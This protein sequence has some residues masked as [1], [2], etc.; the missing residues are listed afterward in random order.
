MCT[1]LPSQDKPSTTHTEEDCTEPNRL[2]EMKREVGF[3]FQISN[4]MG[5]RKKIVKVEEK[6]KELEEERAKTDTAR[7]TVVALEGAVASA[8]KYLESLREEHNRLNAELQSRFSRPVTASLRTRGLQKQ[9][10]KAVSRRSK[11]KCDQGKKKRQKEK[12]R[13]TTPLQVFQAPIVSQRLNKTSVSQNLPQ[14]PKRL[15]KQQNE[16]VLID[17]R[18]VSDASAHSDFSLTD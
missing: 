15:R 9:P 4:R 17:D 18:S 13:S 2:L 8:T 16:A 5:S 7:A 6:K 12:H 10:R 11:V 1:N 14:E 3:F